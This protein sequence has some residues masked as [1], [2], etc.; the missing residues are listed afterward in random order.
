[1]TKILFEIEV[2][3]GRFLRPETFMRLAKSEDDIKDQFKDQAVTRI[4]AIRTIK[5]K[6]ET[7]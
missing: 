6:G 1:M 3:R 4:T 5:L 7:K 2:S